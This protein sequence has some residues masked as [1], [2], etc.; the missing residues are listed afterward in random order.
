MFLKKH[1]IYNCNV[2]VGWGSK[3][4]NPTFIRWK[5]VRRATRRRQ[6]V[7]KLSSL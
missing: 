7:S 6:V 1:K 2:I 5:L 4:W 3:T